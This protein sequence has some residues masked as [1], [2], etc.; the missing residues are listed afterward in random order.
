MNKYDLLD[1]MMKHY[2]T[3]RPMFELFCDKFFELFDEDMIMELALSNCNS[4]S[5]IINIDAIRNKL[6]QE[7]LSKLLNKYWQVK[8]IYDL[9]IKNY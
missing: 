5:I 7:N 6:N 8:Y 2:M 9:E 4:A 3:I 1:I